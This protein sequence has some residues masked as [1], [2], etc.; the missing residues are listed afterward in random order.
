MAYMSLSKRLSSEW[1]AAV[2]AYVV[3]ATLV[4]CGKSAPPSVAPEPLE[5]LLS[6]NT[7]CYKSF[8]F[9]LEGFGDPTHPG[10]ADTSYLVIHGLT[11]TLVGYASGPA[12]LALAADGWG[13][14]RDEWRRTTSDSL[15]VGFTRDSTRQ[16]FQLALFEE[17]ARGVCREYEEERD[18]A[19]VTLLEQWDVVLSRIQC[20]GLR[21]PT[22]PPPKRM[23]FSTND[24]T[25]GY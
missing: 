1:L 5:P 8:S 17:G 10:D 25:P 11:D 16:A 4:A 7:V 18:T 23:R 14:Q 2:G 6:T 19:D 21:E 9:G 15:E 12:W 24:L 20:S 13:P 3:G 22:K